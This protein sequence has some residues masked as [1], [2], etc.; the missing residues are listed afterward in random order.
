MNMGR[1]V[2]K[3]E[4]SE[5]ELIDLRSKSKE[6]SN[7]FF[8]FRVQIILLRNKG[9]SLKDIASIQETSDT[10]VKTWLRR[11]KEGG[12]NSLYTLEGQ[13]R[14]LILQEETDAESIKEL[15]DAEPQRISLVHEKAQEILG[16]SFCLSTLHTFLKKLNIA[17]RELGKDQLKSQIQKCIRLKNKNYENL[18]RKQ[19]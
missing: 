1:N 6:S 9:Y 13:G 4:L 19:I 11:Y 7:K 5:E 18:K 12:V 17:G 10:T 16:K 14:K 3:L 2:R 15:V 8:V